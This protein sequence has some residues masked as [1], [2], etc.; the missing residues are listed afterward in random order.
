MWKSREEKKSYNI[1]VLYSILEGLADSRE[2]K[3]RE[4]I[5]ECAGPCEIRG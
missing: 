1:K 3:D 2:R 4:E 5:E